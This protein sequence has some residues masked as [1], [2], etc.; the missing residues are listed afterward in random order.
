MATIDIDRLSKLFLSQGFELNTIQLTAF[1]HYADLLVDRNE[2]INLTAI[3]DPEEIEEKHFLDSCLPLKHFDIPENASVIDVG[4]GAGF[5]G[6]PF[7]II[8]PDIA[9]TLLDSLQK[10]INFLNEVLSAANLTADAIH[11]RAEDM[12]RLPEMRERYDVAV[13][14]AVARLSILAEYCLPFVKVGGHFIALKGGN[15]CNEINSA[16]NAIGTL[17]GHIEKVIEYQLPHEDKRTLVVIKKVK[18][19]Q[20]VYPRSKG[21][22]NKKPL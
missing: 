22:M 6:I 12:G 21:K 17:G 4:T 14:R 1:E 19:T 5:P 2:N 20:P 11:G 8:R 13:A 10:R 9:L 16:L 3:T 7:K 15:C 18:P